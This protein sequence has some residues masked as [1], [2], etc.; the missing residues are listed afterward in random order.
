MGEY[1]T[2]V[3]DWLRAAT[4]P[5][6]K[7]EGPHGLTL[8]AV[9]DDWE[10]EQN[11]PE[12]GRRQH[13]FVSVASLAL[14]LNRHADPKLAEV[15]V[16]A[17]TVR[18][19]LNPTIP[20]A[21]VVRCDLEIHP[22]ARRWKDALGKRL[23]QREFY[24]LVVSADEDLGDA[25]DPK[26]DVLGRSSEFIA[27]EV[28]KLRIVRGGEYH[29]ELDER[30]N[31]KVRGGTETKD[32]K[33]QLPSRLEVCVPWFL[34]VFIV[35]PPGIG[36]DAEVQYTLD[37]HVEI[38]TET[39]AKNPV[40]ILTA[41]GLAMLKHE[42]RRDACAWL[43]HLLEDDFLVGMGDFE[44]ATVRDYGPEFSLSAQP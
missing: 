42:A 43:S 28:A 22:R 9:P 26:G 5:L 10:F 16:G 13:R 29:A 17:S 30:G 11:Y 4:S 24:R 18:A 6:A 40:F 14:W 1:M 21:D 41:P 27:A 25:V 33:G 3:L 31:Y 35:R 37:I 44:G 12:R 8:H 15:L 7:S 20:N 2:A 36:M 19:G 39:D 34:D 38:D 32:V 23:T